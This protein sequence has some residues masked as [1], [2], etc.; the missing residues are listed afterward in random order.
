MKKN[1]EKGQALPL[2][3]IAIVLG[4][5][6]LP[7]FLGHVDSSIIGSRNYERMLYEQYTC[8]SG[9]EHAVWS[10]TDGTVAAEIS[11]PGDS[12]SYLL[13]ESVNNLTANVTICNSYQ[14]LAQ[15]NF[16]SGTW[17]GGS[18]WLDSWT[19]SGE[20]AVTNSGTPYE[21]GYH[22]RL[23]SNSGVVKRSINLSHNINIYLNFWA[24]VDDFE[25]G[26]TATC[27]ISSDGV[28]WTTVYTWTSTDSDGAYH[29]RLISLAPYEMTS[30]FWIS[31]NSNMSS[32]S[33]YF[34]I[35]KLEVIWLASAP[36]IA[37][38]D[39]F[40]SGD[41]TGG[42]NWLDNWDLSGD[43][44]ITTSGS[45]YQGSYHLRLIDGTGVAKRSVDLSDVFLA[46]IQFWA[47]VNAFEGNDRATCQVSSD[48]FT[49]TTVYTWTRALDDNTY[50]LYT[51]DLSAFELTGRF[52]ISFHA[53]MNQTDDY[54]YV[55]NIN[56]EKITGY[57][58]T[59]EA[60]DSTLKAVVGIEDGKAVTVLFWS[61]V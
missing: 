16:N 24:K 46:T 5:L 18:G 55:D 60:G 58:I 30:Q 57:G 20:S 41:V 11:D 17:T 47:K 25:S 8:D 32:T 45:P 52:W 34:Y 28:N 13:P 1:G 6:V 37:A 27:R 2:V 50:H 36:T 38:S 9:V 3:M 31:F 51:I 10:L 39:D 61:F 22:L 33:D 19:H 26:E 48:G 14:I 21:G 44:A 4:A 43:A 15:D 42:I 53:N 59:V 40:E 23:R 49:W 12:A 56:V 29:H 7:P 54:F 35:D